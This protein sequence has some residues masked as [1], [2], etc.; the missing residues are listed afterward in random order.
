[1]CSSSRSS[2]IIIRLT[3]SQNNEEIF[4]RSILHWPKDISGCERNGIASGSAT[5]HVANVPD[6][7]EDLFFRGIVCEAELGALIVRE[8]H[9]CN[10]G[11]DVRDLKSFCNVADEFKHKAEVAVSYA[12]GPVYQETNVDGVVARLTAQHLLVRT[13]FLDKRFYVF[14][15]TKPGGHLVREEA[16]V[17][18]DSL[19]GKKKSQKVN[20]DTAAV[21][22]TVRHLRDC[23][24]KAGWKWSLM[25]G[26]GVGVWP[27]TCLFLCKEIKDKHLQLKSVEDIV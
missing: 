19:F 7:R 5:A 8:L 11:T 22:V 12:A 4:V 2:N 15:S 21:R 24:S 26:W 6:G 17:S 14:C 18:T 10:L 25:G 9:S 23:L 1:M 16:V 3:I 27:F 20:T 13:Q